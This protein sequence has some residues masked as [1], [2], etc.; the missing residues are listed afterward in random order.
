MCSQ[1]NGR[2]IKSQETEPSAEWRSIDGIAF[3]RALY[4]GK[5]QGQSDNHDRKESHLFLLWR[6]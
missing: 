5:L 4:D 3:A 1:R 2:K 6:N